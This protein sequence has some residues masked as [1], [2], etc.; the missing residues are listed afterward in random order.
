MNNRDK[1]M[2]I[3]AGEGGHF[4]QALRLIDNLNEVADVNRIHIVIITDEENSNIEQ[5]K[6]KNV[7]MYYVI[8]SPKA[9]TGGILFNSIRHIYRVMTTVVPLCAR[10][11]PFI[12]SL[13]PGVVIVPA[14]I[15]KIFGG[16]VV[17]IET[18]SR[19]YSCS[20]TGKL[21]SVIADEFYVQNIELTKIYKSAIYCGRL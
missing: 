14:L 1:L 9:K 13:G 4:A 5:L 7:H 15:V 6:K 18:W 3:C 16:V 21:M 12:L 8:G 10:Y 20:A 17:H 11:R 2:I 19:F